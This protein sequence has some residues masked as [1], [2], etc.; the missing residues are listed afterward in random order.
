MTLF[1]T[2]PAFKAPSVWTEL[3]IAQF[4]FN[5]DE[6]LW[7]LY[8]PNRKKGWRQYDRIK[9]SNLDDL[10]AELEGDPTRIFWG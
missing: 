2:R 8:H 10:L 4:R 7:R 9:P 3:P 1:E 5:L 6:K